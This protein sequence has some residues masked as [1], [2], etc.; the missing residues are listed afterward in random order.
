VPSS[1]NRFPPGTRPVVYVEVYDPQLGTGNVQLGLL[2]D[3]VRLKT[4]EKA[5]SS[6]T[7]PISELV[8]QG[9]PTVP[10]IFSLPTDKLSAGDYALRIWARD[11]AQNVTPVRTGDFSVE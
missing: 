5:Y 6:N 2:F 8:R 10:V 11:S 7:I 4:H 1:N 9:H 3:V